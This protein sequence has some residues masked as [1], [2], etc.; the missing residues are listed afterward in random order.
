M[1][2]FVH[3]KRINSFPFR[4]AS[5]FCKPRFSPPQ[6]QLRTATIKTFLRKIR[7]FANLEST[8]TAA[9]ASYKPIKTSPELFHPF[10]K[11]QKG[12]Q[13]SL[14]SPCGGVPAGTAHSVCFFAALGGFSCRLAAVPCCCRNKLQPPNSCVTK[15]QAARPNT[16]GKTAASTV[17]FTLPVSFLTVNKVVAHGKCKSENKITHTAVVAVHPFAVNNSCKAGL[18]IDTRLPFA[19]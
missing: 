13:K 3:A 18:S 6:P 5:R 14:F 2:L 10:C 9:A 16:V 1:V 8:H 12:C 15:R 4:E 19:I 11:A 7:G 17:H